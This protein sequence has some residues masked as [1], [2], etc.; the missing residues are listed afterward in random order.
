MNYK[1]INHLYISLEHIIHCTF[2]D[3]TQ[4]IMRVGYA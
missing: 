2:I 3:Q 4:V 1:W